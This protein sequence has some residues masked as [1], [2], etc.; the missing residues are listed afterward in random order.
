[1]R[2]GLSVVALFLAG[3]LGRVEAQE[4]APIT[5]ATSPGAAVHVRTFE[6]WMDDIWAQG[7]V[8]LVAELVQ[9]LYV[10]HEL[11]STRTITA[12]AYASEIV[13]V[14]RA[15]PD[16][17]FLIHDC[18]AINDRLWV[19]WTMVGTSAST[20]GEIRRKG[21]QVYRFQ[22]GR[23]AETWNL[24]PPTDGVWPEQNTPPTRRGGPPSG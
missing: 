20:G 11:D 23:L 21:M 2:V 17:R 13:G 6:R 8:E 18:A 24:M 15:L 4:S 16:V 10:R 14:R 7:H 1:M 12:A 3:G 9:P 5:C 22:D 19:R